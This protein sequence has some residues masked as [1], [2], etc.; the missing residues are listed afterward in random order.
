MK[1]NI[2]IV[3]YL[4]N[5]GVDKHTYDHDGRTPFIL[6]AIEGFVVLQYYVL[7]VI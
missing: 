3:E 5:H 2:Q 1:G 7:E 6:A 4:I